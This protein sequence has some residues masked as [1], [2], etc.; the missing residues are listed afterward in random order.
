MSTLVS[1]MYW[2]RDDQLEARALMT[3]PTMAPVKTR[4]A[5]CIMTPATVEA[6][7]ASGV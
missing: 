3:P 6:H 4:S 7:H 5:S 1:R 2:R